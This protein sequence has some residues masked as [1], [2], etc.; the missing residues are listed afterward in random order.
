M[1]KESKIW[2]NNLMSELYIPIGS[3]EAVSIFIAAIIGY[4]GIGVMGWGGIISGWHFLRCS[5]MRTN[6]LPNIRIELGKHLALGLEFLVG[7][8]II[9]TIVRPSWDDLGKLAAMI[10]LRT[11]VT[12]MLSW[13]L[14]EVKAEI[15]E[16]AA[17]RREILKAKK[18]A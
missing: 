7:K 8:D 6:H 15:K 9:E 11:I 3:L 13:E 2:Y 4:I 18:N 12:F 14:K 17:H 1:A 10:T 16:E 5:V